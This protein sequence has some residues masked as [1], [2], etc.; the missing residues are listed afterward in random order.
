M[1]KYNVVYTVPFSPDAEIRGTVFEEEIVTSDSTA[2][3]KEVFKKYPN[4]Q[5]QD[6]RPI[7]Y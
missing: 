2:A 6:I 4:A 5:I 1:Q 3:R 7:R